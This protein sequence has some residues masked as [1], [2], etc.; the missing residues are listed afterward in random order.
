MT[1]TVN[2]QRDTKV[3]MSYVDY[4]EANSIT[5]TRPV[6]TYELG[7]LAGG[8]LSQSTST[9]VIET[10][11][12]G[13]NPDR[14]SKRF[15][16]QLNA[17][18]WN[19][20]LYEKPTGIR[21]SRDANLAAAAGATQTGSSR[22]LASTPLWQTLVSNTP[23]SASGASK[24]DCVFNNGKL[25]SNTQTASNGVAASKSNFGTS[26]E[27]FLYFHLGDTVYKVDKAVTDK[28]TIDGGIEDI[29]KTSWSGYGST[30]TELEGPAKDRFLSVVGG[31]LST[32]TIVQAGA[33]ASPLNSY[34]SGK[35]QPWAESNVGISTTASEDGTIINRDTE[36]EIVHR[37]SATGTDV[38][39]TFPITDL[40]IEYDNAITYLTPE[41]L[42][43]LNEP[44]GSYTGSRKISG[45]MSMYLK[46]GSAES[47]GFLKA[48]QEDKRTT[49]AST[50][51]AKFFIGG[52]TG[53]RLVV[54]IPAC[55]FDFPEV[56]IEDVISM[57]VSFHGQEPTNSTGQGG[58]IIL[59]AYKS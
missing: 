55:Q 23:F 22:S 35:Y 11:E 3:Y 50:T 34:A 21:V 16:T 49:S 53:A 9:Q 7:I 56:S 29:C 44:V 45:S 2:F 25:F 48:I 20:D 6:N 5:N 27:Y 31:E 19:F 39:Y 38:T 28:A 52:K 18:N 40:S 15:N 8:G 36:I 46:D 54:E 13:Q 51:S 4:E 59:D 42:A 33:N 41:E 58:E 24:E 37:S 57:T 32:G 10:L 43:K 26:S 17:V 14:S 30:M 12:S 47:A 1:T